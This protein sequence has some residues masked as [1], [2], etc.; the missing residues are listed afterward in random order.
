MNYKI[1]VKAFKDTTEEAMEL[2]TTR[3]LRLHDGEAI[4]AY[5]DDETKA[6]K[7]VFVNIGNRIYKFIESK[8]INFLN[9]TARDNVAYFTKSTTMVIFVARF[10]ESN[11]DWETHNMH[12]SSDEKLCLIDDADR[13]YVCT[14][15]RSPCDMCFN[16]TFKSETLEY[17]DDVSKK[18][19]EVP[20]FE[21]STNF[22]KMR[23]NKEYYSFGQSPKAEK[24]YSGPSVALYMKD[25]PLFRSYYFDMDTPSKVLSAGIYY[26][27]N[28]NDVKMLK[29]NYYKRLALTL[30]H[31]ERNPS[32]YI[33]NATIMRM[34]YYGYIRSIHTIPVLMNCTAPTDGIVYADVYTIE[35]PYWKNELSMRYKD[36]M[37]LEDLNDDKRH[38]IIFE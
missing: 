38:L 21:A 1:T 22:S 36:T 26:S 17:I 14:S 7:L 2:L 31:E 4:V 5:N 33:A 28:G 12:F 32:A 19:T 24:L 13:V 30:K 29:T 3:K 15:A 27:T 10:L 34:N 11:I 18:H 35:D 25:T 9:K 20:V 6:K 16:T 37:P 8:T 23:V